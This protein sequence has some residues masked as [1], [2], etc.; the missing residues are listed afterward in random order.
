MALIVHELPEC[1]VNGDSALF[2][3]GANHGV[4][5]FRA[6][7]GEPVSISVRSWNSSTRYCDRFDDRT[8]CD[9]ETYVPQ[10]V[11]FGG[12]PFYV[13]VNQ[14]CQWCGYAE[15]IE[16]HRDVWLCRKCRAFA[17]RVVA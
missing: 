8:E 2:I 13:Y 7:V 9:Y 12:E 4:R 6:T 16:R 17:K 11:E 10:L 14:P 5:P 3:G 1:R 15:H